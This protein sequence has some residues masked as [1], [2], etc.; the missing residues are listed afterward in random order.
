MRSL[1]VEIDKKIGELAI[2]TMDLEG[3]RVTDPFVVGA[4]E[5]MVNRLRPH[6]CGE[7]FDFQVCVIDAP[8]LNAFALPGGPIV[9]YTELIE[10]A[11]EAEQV[12]GVVG[13]EMA[14]VTLRHGLQRISGSVGV[15]VAL[16][17]IMGDATGLMAIGKE[18]LQAGAITSYSRE[19]ES[20]ADMEGLRMLH[21]AR[22][23]ATAL[24]RFFDFLQREQGELPG[25]VT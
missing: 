24:A 20:Q 9:V 7:G 15:L 3:G 10:K 12:A 1:P 11:T 5:E 18:L 21:A 4:V 17:L 25:A 14:H 6:A 19:Q 16:E 8:V 13:H 22:I 23:D 2:E